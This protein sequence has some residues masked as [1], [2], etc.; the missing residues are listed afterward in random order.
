MDVGQ[1][2][3]GLCYPVQLRTPPA[4]RVDADATLPPEPTQVRPH[5][6]GVQ[7]H[8]EAEAHQG[9]NKIW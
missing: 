2:G 9:T 3:R 4:P 1:V 6:Q 8:H 7:A 5:W